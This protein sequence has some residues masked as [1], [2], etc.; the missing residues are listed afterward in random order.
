MIVTEYN[1][2]R[3]DGVRLF[4][5]YSDKDFMIRKESTGELYDEAI[6]I[7]NSG[8]IYTETDIPIDDR[9]IPDDKALN[10]LL[11]GDEDETE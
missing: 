3:E 7:E 11:G 5:T 6:D 4:R 8:N 9:D 2:T 1:M 10:I